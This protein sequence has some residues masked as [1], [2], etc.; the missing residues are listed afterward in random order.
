MVFLLPIESAA[1]PV[2]ISRILVDISLTAY[3]VPIWRKLRPAS[4]KKRIKKGSK[5]FRFFKNP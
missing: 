5:N 3:K 2:G 4:M 1:I